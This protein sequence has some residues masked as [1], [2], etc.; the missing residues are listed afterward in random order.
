[1]LYLHGLQ[2]ISIIIQ[3]FL[4]E[5]LNLLSQIS[6]ERNL[7]DLKELF[8]LKHTQVCLKIQ[9]E[10]YMTLDHKK[11]CQAFKISKKSQSVSYRI[12]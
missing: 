6:L 9:M 12:C 4:K 5:I 10:N 11:Q 1:M 3:S 7:R 2:L 8:K